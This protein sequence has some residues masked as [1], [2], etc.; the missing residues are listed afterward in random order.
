ML[1]FV[2][3]IALFVLLLLRVPIEIALAMIGAVGFGSIIGMTPA[4]K[5]GGTVAA[6]TVLSYDFAV[7]PMFI[8]MG[9]LVARSGISKELYIASNVWFG[10]MRGGLAIATIASC[11]GFSAVCGS[12]L[13]TAATMAKVAIPPMRSFKYSNSLAAGS[14]AAGGT[15]GILIPPSVALVLYGIMTETDIT[16]LFAAGL[17]PGILGIV[18]YM[19]AISI[20][21]RISPSIGPAAEKHSLGEKIVALK[22]VF[23]ILLLFMLV[24]GGLYLGWFTPTEAA[25]VGAGGAL[26]IAIARRRISW[27]SFIDVMYESARMS[28]TLLTILIGAL[29][30]ANFINV[31]RLPQALGDWVTGVDVAPLVVIFF[32]MAIYIVLGCFLESISMMLLTVPIFYPIVAML[33]FDLI[34][35]GVLVIVVIEISLITPP[36]GL[37]IFV[38]RAV[39]P[40]IPIT[41]VYRGVIAFILADIVR[42]I[43]LLAFP[44]ITLWLPSMIH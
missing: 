3:F 17:L 19:V 4:L 41:T 26:L 6:E 11:G 27:E 20:W 25:G 18:L 38:M 10:H 16:K 23:G 36:I 9:N 15:L 32:I 21:V 22:G 28:V 7:I 29:I 5:C 44:V 2:A 12:S 8:L 40:D 35:F 24:M 30:F 37:N 34:W 39:M 14:V 13:A 43:L 31:A 1:I 42:V 33:G